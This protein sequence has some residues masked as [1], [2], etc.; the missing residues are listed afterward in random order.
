MTNLNFKAPVF[1]ILC[2]V[3]FLTPIS[4]VRGADL[5]SDINKQN[6]VFAGE[7]GAN[8]SSSDPRLVVGQVITVLISV[9][10]TLLTAWTV[11]GGFLI[12]SSAG[13][14]EKIDQGKGIIKN[15][16]IGLIIILSA[17]A[18]AN[19]VYKAWA[20]PAT[21]IPQ[22]QGTPFDKDQYKP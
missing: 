15:G 9:L 13:D 21:P 8:L 19:F 20:Q 11:Y 22:N 4:V 3:L 5:F 1:A 17:Y 2:L 12:L 7:K 10:G 18:I 16:V 6:Q 14:D